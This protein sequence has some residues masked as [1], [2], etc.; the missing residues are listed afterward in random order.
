MLL[1]LE[2]NPMPS[3]M[4]FVKGKTLYIQ[5]DKILKD[6]QLIIRNSSDEVIVQKNIKQSDHALVQ[7]EQPAGTYKVQLI[8]DDLQI[9]KNIHIK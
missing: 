7:I 4:F 3:F 2:K 5:F 9:K 8:K 6:T 1:I